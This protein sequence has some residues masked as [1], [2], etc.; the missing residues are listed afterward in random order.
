[1]PA[2]TGMKVGYDEHSTAQGAAIGAL[3][4]GL[5]EAAASVVLPTHPRPVVLLDLGSSE[6]RNALGITARLAA[7]LRRHPDQPIQ[8]VYSDL[9]TNNF[10]RLFA[11]LDEA[12]RAGRLDSG[13]YTSAS[14]GSFY[15]ELAPPGTV[16]IAT[17][18][19]S[20]LWLDRLPMT[21]PDFVSYRR[22]HPPRPG[23]NVP[24]DRAE[25]FT[26]QAERD[27]VRFLE[28]RAVELVPGG[29]LLVA[30]PGDSTDRRICDGLYDLLNDACLD[31]VRAG[32]LPPERYEA[33]TLPVYFRTESELLAPLQGDS[34]LGG[35][36]TVDR[37]ETQVV[38]PPFVE[39]FERTGDAEALARDYVG[40][41]RA[42]SEPVVAA[43]LEGL[44]NARAVVDSL[45]DRARTRMTEDPGRYD[46]RY[47]QPAIA[48]TRQDRP[49]SHP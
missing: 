29:K 14:A 49:T 13:V 9:A 2:T 27:W 23:L 25:A 43:V 36:F 48:L 20:V 21:V 10:N 18:F 37:V 31:L 17:C 30:T 6:G 4:G 40:F 24:P 47:I 8:A 41:I 7:G 39:A 35:V 44:Q 22:P 45:Y 28:C 15:T 11:N 42:F 5:D 46:F 1:M 32:A 16:H 3:A 19:N 33:L 12:R 38:K 26:R 34:P